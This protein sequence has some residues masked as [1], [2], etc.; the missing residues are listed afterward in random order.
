MRHGLRPRSISFLHAEDQTLT[1]DQN[2]FCA[3]SVYTVEEI[4][5][6]VEE[7]ERSVTSPTEKENLVKKHS[8]VVALVSIAG[9]QVHAHAPESK[10]IAGVPF[11]FVAGTSINRFSAIPT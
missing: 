5:Y 3:F 1:T 11:E 7:F 9:L 2:F 10:L 6:E 4:L 8:W